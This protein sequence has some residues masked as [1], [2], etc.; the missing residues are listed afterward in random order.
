[1]ELRFT[2][3]GKPQGK[4]RARTVHNKYTGRVHSYTPSKTQSYEDL[5][6]WCYKESGGELIDG[7][8]ID[9]IVRAK[10]EIPKSYTKKQRQAILEG[11]MLPQVKPDCDNI[12]KVVM[13]ALN[14]VAYVDDKQ[15]TFC[16]CSKDY[17]TESPCVEIVVIDYE[18]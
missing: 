1:M 17:T 8:S 12:L 2:V 14:G 10:F 5:I 7:R 13:D 15:V 18:F 6:R 16:S 3:A 11:R 4:A 9:V